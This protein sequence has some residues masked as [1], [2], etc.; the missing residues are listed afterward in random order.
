MNWFNNHRTVRQAAGLV[1]RR[2]VITSVL[3]IISIVRLGNLAAQTTT[4]AEENM[5]SLDTL[6]T[7]NT[8]ASDIR[9]IRN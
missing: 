6:G 7:V 8:I 4:L 9:A 3:G 1:R 2:L 5:P